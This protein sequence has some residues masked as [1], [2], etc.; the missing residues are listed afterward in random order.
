MQLRREIAWPLLVG[1][2]GLAV[3][4]LVLL[5]KPQ[6]ARKPPAVPPPPQVATITVHPGSKRLVVTSQGT[7]RPRREIDLVAQV[8]GRVVAVARDFTDG[9]FFAAG[10]V[11]VQ[12]ETADYEHALTEAAARVAQARQALATERGRGRQARR[13]WRDLG[14]DAANALFLRK[15]QLASAEAQLQAAIAAREQA[16]LSLARTAIA[17]PFDGRVRQTHVNVGQ[18]VTAGTRVARVYATDRVEVRLPLTDRQVGLLDL[19]LTYHTDQRNEPVPVTIEGEFG[20]R[21]WQWAGELVRTDASIDVQSRV[22]YAIAEVV[23][24]F[25][26]D[27]ASDRPP[28]AIG[29]F[30]QAHIPGR[31]MQGVVKLPRSA[32]RPGNDVW[33]VDDEDR[34]DIV[35]V[36][37]LQADAAG[38]YVRGAL[39]DG[40]RV[41]VSPLTIAVDG[42]AVVP[43]PRGPPEDSR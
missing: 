38:A 41:I 36:T 24:P 9:G 34:L 39:P 15:P 21:R 40:A 33:V 42:M 18:Y 12:I 43:Q 3:F 22:L 16:R 25:E 27:P 4:L 31:Q 28:L 7:I 14:D 19:P 26:R 37:V 29:L 35:P 5:G 10:N 23:D 30:V 17:A 6:P 1:A 13:E 2:V 11:L 8:G 32:L 20:G